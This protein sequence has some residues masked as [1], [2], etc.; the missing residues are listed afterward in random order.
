LTRAIQAHDPAWIE[1]RWMPRLAA[2]RARLD[3]IPRFRR[4]SRLSGLA[5]PLSLLGGRA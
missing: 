4:L 2:W 1:S 3:D 5:L